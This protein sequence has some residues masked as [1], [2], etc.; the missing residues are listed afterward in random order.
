VASFDEVADEYDATRP[1]YPP[2]VYDALG[3]VDGLIVLDVGAGTGIATR[4]LLARGARVVA[5]DRGRRMLALATTRTP[6]LPA[7][8]ADGAVL[9]VADGSVDLVCFAQA[10]HWLN[11][12]TRV[13]EVRRVLRPDGRW[14]GWWSHVWVEG[15]AWFDAYWT[16][17]EYACPGTHRDQRETDWGATIA[18]PGDLAASGPIVVPWV[19]ELSIDAWMSD[20][21]THS[22]VSAL[23][24]EQRSC[25]LDELRQ[26]ITTQFPT[27]AMAVRYETWLWIAMRP[28]D[29]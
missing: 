2:G 3:D 24:E 10:W 20:Q 29:A 17:I 22:Y 7:V 23:P 21:G 19:R 4:Q 15:E 26:I 16:A 12:V 14:A 25:L 8:V 13:D 27:G 1:L 5:V 6:G 11:P 9:P 18:D 28:D